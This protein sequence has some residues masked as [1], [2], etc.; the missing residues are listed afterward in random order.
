MNIFPGQG[1]VRKMN[2]FPGQEKVREA[3]FESG[4]F[5]EIGK[6]QG[7]VAEF[8]NFVRTEMSV[9]VFLIFRI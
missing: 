5:A 9:A 8:Q 1:K 3:W 6:S 4:K 7:K 2:I